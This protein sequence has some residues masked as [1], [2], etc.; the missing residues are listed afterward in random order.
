MGLFA[1][2][3]RLVLVDDVERWKAADAKAVAEYLSPR[4]AGHRA[5]ARRRGARRKDVAAREGAGRRRRRPRLRGL[6]A[7]CRS[8]SPSSSRASRRQGERRRLPRSRRAR[9]R[10]TSQELATEVDKLS[11]WAGDD[12]IGADEVE[13]LVAARAE[14]PPFVLTDAWGRRDVGAVLARV[15]DDPRAL[16]PRGE[17]HA[18]V[19]RLGGARRA[20]CRPARR[21][22]RRGRPPARRGR[23]AEDAPLRRGEGIRPVAQLLGRGATRRRS[24]TSPISTS[25]SR[26]AAGCRTSS[27]SSARS[28]RL[29]GAA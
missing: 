4:R 22:D 19:G 16:G 20:A 26:A 13:L 5:R 15:R 11:T 10:R 12:A 27:S 23:R 18:L 9:R 28:S 25:R 3:G 21:L 7:S 8:G 2:G 17:V 24:S 1:R 14:I 29:R 6:E